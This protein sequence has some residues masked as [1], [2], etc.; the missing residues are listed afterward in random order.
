[1]LITA[2]C[3]EWLLNSL[4]SHL[5]IEQPPYFTFSKTWIPTRTAVSCWVR[6]VQKNTAQKF[7][8]GE[9]SIKESNSITNAL[10]LANDSNRGE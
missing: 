9:G 2:L 7:V 4:C 1:M 6:Y 8:V 3:N 10:M 5:H